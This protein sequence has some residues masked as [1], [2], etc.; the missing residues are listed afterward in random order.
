MRM[1]E[2]KLWSD[3]GGRPLLAVTLDAVAAANCFD[4]VVVVA[5]QLR[6]QEIATL[7]GRAGLRNVRHVEGG[8]RRQDSVA[9][10]LPL[11]AGDDV[12]CVHDAAR[13]LVPPQL[14]RDVLAAARDSGAATAGIASV[15]TVK[16][17]EGGR[18]ITTLPR[19]GLIATQTPQAFRTDLL[20][21]AHREAVE[22][23]YAGDD[24]ASLVEHIGARV[25]VV[26]GDPC[27]LKVTT[28]QD[29]TMVRALLA[30]HP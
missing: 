16:Q 21:R 2:D 22:H 13:P 15:D 9:A 19:A 1:G 5:P 12:V 11:C 7:A 17:V 18:V 29:L 28:P 24:D 26:P 25:T 27:N 20:V 8:E 6:W 30:G 14:F 3:V 10:A 23:G 4:T